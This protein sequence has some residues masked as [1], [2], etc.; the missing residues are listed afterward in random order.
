MVDAL[1]AERSAT[2][3]QESRGDDAFACEPGADQSTP[4]MHRG[5]P[6]SS[7]EPTP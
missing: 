4:K 6:Q 7:D 1:E 5:G 3:K 2:K